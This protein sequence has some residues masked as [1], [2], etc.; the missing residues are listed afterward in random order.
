MKYQI[1]PDLFPQFGLLLVT[2][3]L[4]DY[5]VE[6]LDTS[7]NSLYVIDTT[8]QPGTVHNLAVIGYPQLDYYHEHE[9]I[10]FFNRFITK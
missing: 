10:H 3:R 2:Y 9:F 4:P 8:Y 7:F 1:H 6:N 5:S